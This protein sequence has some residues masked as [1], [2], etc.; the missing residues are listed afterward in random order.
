MGRLGTAAGTGDGA[1]APAH[2]G[3]VQ[4]WSR[5]AAFHNTSVTYIRMIGKADPPVRGG[6]VSGLT[7]GPGRYPADMSR[8]G[9]GTPPPASPALQVGAPEAGPSTVRDPARIPRRLGLTG[10]LMM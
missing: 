5:A 8:V 6:R 3:R 9:L 4:D 1:R 7:V 2:G 10:A